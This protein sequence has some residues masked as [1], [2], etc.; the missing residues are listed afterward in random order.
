MRFITACPSRVAIGFLALLAFAVQSA[1]NAAPETFELQHVAVD[2]VTSFDSKA[3]PSTWWFSDQTPATQERWPGSLKGD[4]HSLSSDSAPAHWRPVRVPANLVGAG[5]VQDGHRTIWYRKAFVLDQNPGEQ[6]ALR[7]GEISDRDQ[8]Y[9]NG[10]RIAGTGRFGE[11]RPQAYDQTRV[12]DVPLGVLRSGPNILLIEVQGYFDWELGL[13]R[14]RTEIGPA[15]LIRAQYFRENALQVYLLV[16]Y[17]TVASYFLFLFVRR[18]QERENLFFALF[19]LTLVMYHFLRTQ[20]KY[21]LGFDFDSL[22]RFQYVNLFLTLPLF[23]YFLRSYYRLDESKRWVRVWDLFF[24]GLSGM[25]AVL[26]GGL[27]FFE[28]RVWEQI[29]QS[30]VQPFVWGTYVLGCVSL[31]GIQMRARDR[32]AFIMGAAMVVMLVCMVLDVLSSQGRIN[33]PTTLT[34]AFF[35]F[36]LGMALILANRFVRVHEQVRTLNVDLSKTN[37]AYSRFVPREFLSLLGR[38]TIIDVEI[39]DQVRRQMTILF[40][41]IRSFTSLSETMTPEENFNFLNSYL[42]HMTPLVQMNN[43]FIDKYIGDAIMALFPDSAED[44]LRAAIA[45]QKDILHYNGIRARENKVPIEVGIGVHTGTLMLGTIGAAERMEGTVISDAVN[46]A[47]R[48]EGVTKMFGAGV[49]ISGPSLESVPDYQTR[50]RCRF[51]GHLQVKGK[52]ENIAVYEAYDGAAPE[53]IEQRAASAADYARATADYQAGRFA[54]AV[55]G[56]QAVLAVAPADRAAQFYLE[57]ARRLQSSGVDAQWTAV[58][59]LDTK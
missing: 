35:L 57:E 34:F 7:L 11:T 10:S 13:Y 12:Y 38:N 28:I 52:S 50:Y 47:S 15:R 53:I 21:E 1:L 54:E 16:V 42:K 33:L 51:L 49:C 14:D 36:V 46:L 32:D 19:A 31:I 9:L 17:L 29:N 24:L 27:F 2:R 8:V 20:F 44:A 40:S 5:L 30:V 4:A 25:Y 58:V 26:V 22:K 3:G 6:F 43:G 55:Q 39:G 45:M 56:F 37:T 59:R 48:I 18:R 23:Y 41:D